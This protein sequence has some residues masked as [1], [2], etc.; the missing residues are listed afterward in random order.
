MIIGLTGPIGAGKSTVAGI[1]KEQGAVIIDADRLG[2]QV[3]AES[4][5]LRR[6][7]AQAFGGD[8]FRRDGRLDRRRLAARA[9]AGPESKA[10]LDAIL[11]F[12]SEFH[13]LIITG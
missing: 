1:L 12:K 10:Q 9:F 8:I 2:H 6:R 5:P 11:A 3:I 13:D 4:E 7:L